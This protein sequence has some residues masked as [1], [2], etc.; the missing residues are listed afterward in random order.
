VEGRVREPV[1]ARRAAG[2]HTASL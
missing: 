2:Q 1:Q